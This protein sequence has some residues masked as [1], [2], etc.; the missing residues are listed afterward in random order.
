MGCNMRPTTLRDNELSFINSYTGSERMGRYF[1]SEKAGTFE[2]PAFVLE[3]DYSCCGL[4]HLHFVDIDVEEHFEELYDYLIVAA[5]KGVLV[6]TH[7]V[8][9]TRCMLSMSFPVNECAYEEGEG[10][11]R[12][13][14]F[15][16]KK[17]GEARV[18]ISKPAY[19]PNSDNDI[20]VATVSLTD[21]TYCE[22]EYTI[23]V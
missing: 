21:P 5:T 20:V 3:M 2:D 13:F 14:E 4:L 23:V 17:I 16:R 7:G 1:F 22:D 10:T 15:M 11:R 8:R 18:S 19:N 12:F 6:G 9:Y